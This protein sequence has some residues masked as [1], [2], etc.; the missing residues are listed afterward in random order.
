MTKDKNK[1][2]QGLNP[3]A[4]FAVGFCIGGALTHLMFWSIKQDKDWIGFWGNIV[5]AI[6][7]LI[8]IFFTLKHDR[9]LFEKQKELEKELHELQKNERYLEQIPRQ[10]VVIDELINK[11]SEQKDRIEGHIL[12]EFFREFLSLSVERL[13]TRASGLTEAYMTLENLKY[14]IHETEMEFRL[15]LSLEKKKIE[16]ELDDEVVAELVCDA[17][18][19]MVENFEETID[20]LKSIK[21]VMVAK[22]NGEEEN[23]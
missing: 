2:K 16:G 12:P 17:Q 9:S 10:L 20:Q 15:R 8:G 5:G 6:A 7:T 21:R 22:L 13:M 1:S 23:I 11:L 18:G 3:I 4:E 14:E 19:E